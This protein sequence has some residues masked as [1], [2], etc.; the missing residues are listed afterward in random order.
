M[1]MT[2]KKDITV[3]IVK[4]L[5]SSLKSGKSWAIQTEETQ[6]AN[7]QFPVGRSHIQTIENVVKYLFGRYPEF[8]LRSG[9]WGLALLGGKEVAKMDI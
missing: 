9:V 5:M 3:I 8:Y 2:A 4:P 1:C 7:N 6:P